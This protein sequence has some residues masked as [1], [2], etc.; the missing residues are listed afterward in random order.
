MIRKEDGRVRWMIEMDDLPTRS[1][2]HRLDRMAEI[3]VFEEAALSG[4]P[5]GKNWVEAKRGAVELAMHH[6][7]RSGLAIPSRQQPGV[8]HKSVAEFFEHF[9][10]QAR[11]FTNRS[12]AGLPGQESFTTWSPFT[13]S[14]FDI[15]AG[16]VEGERIGILCIDD[17]D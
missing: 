2:R 12:E 11:C 10:S 7:G 13:D 15:V 5:L 6:A 1:N 9:G 8:R 16:L 17:E 3:F 14:T 4:R